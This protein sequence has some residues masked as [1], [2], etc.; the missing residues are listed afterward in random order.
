MV[1]GEERSGRKAALKNSHATRRKSLSQAGTLRKRAVAL[2]ISF[3]R[4]EV[5]Y[6][7]Q[8]VRETGGQELIDC[9]TYT[10]A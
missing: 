1:S 8:A 2:S 4:F 3:Q 6:L 5:S 9:E 7:C 10:L